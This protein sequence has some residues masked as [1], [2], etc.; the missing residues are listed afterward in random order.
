MIIIVCVRLRAIVSQFRPGN[1]LGSKLSIALALNSLNVYCQQQYGT[2]GRQGCLLRRWQYVVKGLAIPGEVV[3]ADVDEAEEDPVAGNAQTALQVR[4]QLRRPLF[5][6]R[7]ADTADA[8][9][10]DERRRLLRS[11]DGQCGVGIDDHLKKLTE[12]KTN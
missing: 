3:A 11:A 6:L 1:D 8:L 12:K 9:Q 4:V 5:I 10:P 7:A 2:S